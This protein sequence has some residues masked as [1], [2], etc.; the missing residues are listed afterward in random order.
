MNTAT[1]ALGGRIIVL[2]CRF[3]QYFSYIEAVKPALVAISIK[4]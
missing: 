1:S 2:K 3:Q 4:Q